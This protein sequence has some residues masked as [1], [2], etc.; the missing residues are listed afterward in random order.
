MRTAKA[1]IDD[2]RARHQEEAE[3]REEALRSAIDKRE[4]NQFSAVRVSEANDVDADPEEVN[5]QRLNSVIDSL[6]TM[7][8]IKQKEIKSSME[9]QKKAV[10]GNGLQAPVLGKMAARKRQRDEFYAT[11][12]TNAST[13]LE[14]LSTS[15]TI[16]K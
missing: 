5:F 14:R 1:V 8:Q 11:L 2:K 6:N 15:L 12:R 4:K 10:K 16:K 3:R 9:E 7:S 13:K